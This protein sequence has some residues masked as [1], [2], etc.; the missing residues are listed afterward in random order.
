MD[1]IGIRPLAPLMDPIGCFIGKHTLQDIAFNQRKL[2][3]IYVR[4]IFNKTKNKG[5]DDIVSVFGTFI[6]YLTN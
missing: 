2:N 1:E 5:H 3:I 4:Q 6:S